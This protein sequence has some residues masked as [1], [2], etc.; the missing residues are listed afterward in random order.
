MSTSHMP[1]NV[2]AN[3]TATPPPLPP[4]QP[5][6]NYSGYN[7]YR[8]L[9]LNNYY[10]NYGYGNNYRSYGGY[11]SFGMPYSNMSAYNNYG[12]SGDAEN[13]YVIQQ[14]LLISHFWIIN[15]SY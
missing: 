10:S 7:S 15:F 14:S 1:F 13:R 3:Q 8:P 9:G 11:G 2:A 5:V 6:Q 4:R 12:Y